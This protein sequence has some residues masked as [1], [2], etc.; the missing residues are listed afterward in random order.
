[1]NANPRR[2]DTDGDGVGD[3]CDPTADSDGDGVENSSDNCPLIANPGQQ[4]YDFDTVGNACDDD[5]DG[6]GVLNAAENCPTVYNPIPEGAESQVDSDGDGIGDACDFGRPILLEQPPFTFQGSPRT[7][8][9][10]PVMMGRARGRKT[11]SR[12]TSR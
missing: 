11:S 3:A 1:M 7:L 2:P 9:F 8:L 6:D 10:L 12:W 4:D 5:M